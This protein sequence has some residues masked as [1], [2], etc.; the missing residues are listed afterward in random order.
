MRNSALSTLLHIARTAAALLFAA[1]ALAADTVGARWDCGPGGIPTSAEHGRVL[2]LPGV[3]NTRF[4][5]EGFVERVAEQLPNF[6]IEVRT[7]GDAFRMLSNLRAEQRNVATAEQIAAEL[8]DWRRAHPADKLY[9]V[10]YSGGGGIATLVA[11]ALPSD[12]AIDRLVLV[13]PAISPDYPLAERVLP[14]VTEFVASFASTLDLQV[15]WGTLT[16]G[17]IDRK[18]TQ[19]AGA[20]GFALDDPKLLQ[21]RWSKDDLPFGHHGNHLSYLSPRWQDAKLLPTLDPSLTRE[22]VLATW[23]QTCRER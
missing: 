10:G 16:F 22:R 20:V 6:E 8:T 3:G 23:A 21:R 18:N 5:L 11:A 9:V 2:I 1:F 17:T 13:A 7:W 15:G 12:V 4:H 14:H 19:S